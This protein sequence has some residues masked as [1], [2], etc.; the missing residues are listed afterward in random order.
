MCKM[1]PRSHLQSPDI[2]GD[3]SFGLQTYMC[4]M[5]H[6]G[7]HD[8]SCK[9]E[10]GT[11]NSPLPGKVLAHILLCKDSLGVAVPLVFA[12]FGTSFH[13]MRCAVM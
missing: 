4:W 12:C 3:R 2:D 5:C 9:T 6:W 13:L 7:L 11:A 1:E 10:S 8:R